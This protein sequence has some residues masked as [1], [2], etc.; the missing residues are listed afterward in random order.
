MAAA[1]QAA[2]LRAAGELQERAGGLAAAERSRDR[3]REDASER[4]RDARE[5]QGATIQGRGRG[6]RSFRLPRRKEG[7]R[8]PAP[9]SSEKLPDPAGRGQHL[10]VEA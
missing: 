10:D 2:A 7:E 9:P 6:A 1:E 3:G 5:V 8:E 4:V